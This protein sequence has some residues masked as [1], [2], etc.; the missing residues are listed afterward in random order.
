M[1]MLLQFTPSVGFADSSPVKG[2][3]FT[4]PLAGADS[5]CQGEMAAGQKG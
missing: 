4:S 2:A 1:N 5:P 3:L